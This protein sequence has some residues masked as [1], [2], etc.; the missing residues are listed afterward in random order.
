MGKTL[1]TCFSASGQTRRLAQTLA[2]TLGADLREIVPAQKYSGADL[3]WN[4]SRSRSTV[5]MRDR[6]SRPAMA[7]P[8]D[9]SGYDTVFVGFPI[10]WGEAPR[11]VETFLESADFTGKT[12][13]PFATSGGSGMGRSADILQESAPGAR[14][15]NGRIL[16]PGESERVLKKWGD[17]LRI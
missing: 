8:I 14:V 1:V 6:T 15:R 4:N 11:V 17:S 7:E 13:V 9:V 3:D 5:E 16:R 12:I 10:W 2:R